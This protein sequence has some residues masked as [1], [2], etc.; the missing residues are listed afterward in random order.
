M[1]KLKQFGLKTVSSAALGLAKGSVCQTSCG[2]FH[3]PK[4]SRE[5]KNQIKEK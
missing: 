1:Y 3:Q 5:L 2:F 4:M